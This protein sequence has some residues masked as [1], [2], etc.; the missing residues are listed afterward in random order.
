VHDE[1]LIDPWPPHSGCTSP[2]VALVLTYKI[3]G[4][5]TS[6]AQYLVEERT[7]EPPAGSFVLVEM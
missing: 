5:Y 4:P 1:R 3:W 6:R 2:L 7:F